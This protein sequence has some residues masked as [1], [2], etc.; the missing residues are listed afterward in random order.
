MPLLSVIIPVY[1]V[2]KYLTECINSIINQSYNNLEIILI[3]DGSTDRSI[4][5]INDIIER[6]NR[7][8]VKNQPNKGLSAARNHGL[9][10]AKGQYITFVDS[11]DAIINNNLYEEVIKFAENDN[12]I[13]FIQF[14]TIYHWHSRYEIKKSIEEKIIT[15][16]LAILN[17][18]LRGELHVSVCDKIFKKDVIKNIRFPINQQSEDVAVIKDIV[19]NSNKIYISNIGWYGYRYREGSIS[20]SNTNTLKTIQIFK[21][22]LSTY[23]YACTFTETFVDRIN[24]YTNIYWIYLAKNRLYPK[25]KRRELLIHSIHRRLGFQSTIKMLYSNRIHNKRN[26]FLLM[27]LGPKITIKLMRL[28]LPDHTLKAQN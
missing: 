7:I 2:E 10:I 6:D 22:Y 20:K 26:S 5:T 4:E 27:V 23:D 1:N 18:Y 3:N 12:S 19:E 16:K 11:D 15:S 25:E 28:V 24:F 13:D 21:S 14:N 17:S 8:I 9:K